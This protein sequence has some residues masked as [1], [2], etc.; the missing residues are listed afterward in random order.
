MSDDI[1]K[2]LDA[3]LTETL[4]S[5]TA[6]SER[7]EEIKKQYDGKISELEA[8]LKAAD[9]S[10]KF[11]KEH[12]EKL[13]SEWNTK[14]KGGLE[15]DDLL[16]VIPERHKRWIP[17]VQN[18][19]V[20]RSGM[21]ADTEKHIIEDPVKYV[22][23]GSWFAE[24]LAS[25]VASTRGDYLLAQ[26][27]AESAEKLTKALGGAFSVE[28]AALG[29]GTATLGGNTVPTIVE[30]M[31]G[32]V[33]KD[34]GALRR[35]NPTIINMTSQTHNLPNLTTDFTAYIGAE[36]AT[37]S[38]SA[39]A[40]FTGVA[41]LTANKFTGLATVSLELMQDSVLNLADFV[42]VHLG[43]MIARLED[44]VGLEGTG[45]G[46][47]GTITGIRGT[48]GVNAIAAAATGDVLTLV[49]LMNTIYGGEHESTRDN[50]VWWTH[51]WY[52][53]AALQLATGSAGTPWLP[54]IPFNNQGTTRNLLGF[55]VY[56]TSVISRQRTSS[57]GT[58]FFGNPKGLVIGD[59]MGSTFDVDPY[60]LFDKAQVRLRVIKRTGI[61][62]WVPAYFTRLTG[63]V[64]T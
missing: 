7:V 10:L 1:L 57:T 61:V 29:E 22:A 48:T 15:T 59:A 43:E 2:R 32:R 33:I 25:K 35:A 38:D 54:M 63:V 13:E 56:A 28:K 58:M 27:H 52:V 55:P 23:V 19:S 45:S 30:A 41:T 6:A 14:R 47:D 20:N 24:S 37:I 39:S 11:Q 16:S 49:H 17:H 34:N 60:G 51:P 12:V 4:G 8:R 5:A 40:S 26:K 53:K 44:Q 21:S 46:S 3:K 9:D 31:L 64:C 62:T 42:M 36:A 50:G 18:T